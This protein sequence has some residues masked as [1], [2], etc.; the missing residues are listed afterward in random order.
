MAKKKPSPIAVGD[1]IPGAGIVHAVKRV[2]KVVTVQI[3]G[4]D[5]PWADAPDGDDDDEKKE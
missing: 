4:G 2:G 1:E 5:G 3:G